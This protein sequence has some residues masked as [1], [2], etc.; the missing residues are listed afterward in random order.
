MSSVIF[1]ASSP[2]FPIPSLKNRFLCNGEQGLPRPHP[3]ILS[4]HFISLFT[5]RVH[6][7]CTHW[8]SV[9]FLFSW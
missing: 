7:L 8:H 4:F 9:S 3:R 5:C 1:L 6:S 2:R